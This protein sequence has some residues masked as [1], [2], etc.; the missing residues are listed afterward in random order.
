MTVGEIATLTGAAIC[1]GAR[2]NDLI[3]SVAPLDRAGASDLSFLDSSRF[4][5]VLPSTRAGACLMHERFESRAPSG[6]NVLRARDPYRAFVIVA[7]HLFESSLRPASPYE[8]NGIDP[9]AIVHPSAK[10]GLDTTVDPGAVIGPR[11]V[12]G[13]RTVVGANAVIGADVQI[14]QDCS[15]GPGSSVIHAIIGD[16]VICHPGCHIGQDGFRYLTGKD[17]HVKVPQI[18]RVIIQDDVEIGAGSAIDRGGLGDTCIGEGTKIDNLVHIAHNVTIGRH[19]IITGQCGIAGS[20]TV[21][22]HVMF[23]GQAGVADH[24]SIGSGAM[25]GAKSGVVSNVPAGERWLGYPA[26]PGREFLRAMTK[27]RKV[28]IEGTVKRKPNGA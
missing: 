28:A 20:V 6:M 3:T 24:L 17:G 21:G 4:A 19:C 22:D 11:A 12:I 27:L 9:R 25:I 18:G 13:A 8:S 23:G 16:N 14:G 10:L 1:A 2:P 15:I 7:R 26:W 5:D